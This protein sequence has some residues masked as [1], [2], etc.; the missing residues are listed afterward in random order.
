MRIPVSLAA[1]AFCACVQAQQIVVAPSLNPAATAAAQQVALLAPQLLAFA[2][3]QANF[4]ALA[5]GLLQGVP[6]VITSTGTDGIQQTVT[7]Q[8]PAALSAGDA[9]RV[10]ETARQALIS[11]GIAAPTA[12][13]IGVTL[14]G[15]ALPTPLG[16]VPVTGALTGATA[17]VL[18][19]DRQLAGAAT[20]GGSPANVQSLTTG[21]ITGAPITLTTTNA[22]GPS[23]V[24]TFTAPGG[25]MSALEA[26]QAISLAS[27][28][29]AAQGILAPTA[30]QMRVA[31][32][33]GVLATANGTVAIQGVLQGRG[34][35]A[36]S[37]SGLTTSASTLFNTSATPLPSIG[38]SFSPTFST[39]TSGPASSTGGSTGASSNP[40]LGIAV[41]RR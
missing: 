15:G 17:P 3:S 25:P 28:L 33:G 2:G 41:P 34:T 35:V 36:T 8:P 39:G 29:L 37:A 5:A 32:L 20:F 26:S 9:A 13:Q 30:E 40:S 31:L 11:R 1:A 16:A 4:E 7:I 12:E 38:T 18:Q 21:L 10:L 22:A 19:I 24:V 23:Q 6:I 27:Q 14:V